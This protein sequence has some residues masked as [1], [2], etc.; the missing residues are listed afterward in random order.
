MLKNKKISEKEAS[1]LAPR[2]PLIF[3]Q[4]ENFEEQINEFNGTCF[5]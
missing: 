1:V 2:V 3:D 4:N 5:R